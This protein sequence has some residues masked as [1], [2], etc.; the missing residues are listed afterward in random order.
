MERLQ[1]RPFWGKLHANRT[2]DESKWC[3]DRMDYYPIFIEFSFFALLHHK[4]EVAGAGALG[5]TDQIDT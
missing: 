3:F 5:D 2:L 4:A 1:I